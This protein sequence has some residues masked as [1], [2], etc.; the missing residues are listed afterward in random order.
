M[1]FR[2]GRSAIDAERRALLRERS[3]ID[4][5]LARLARAA[6]E[7]EPP[8]GLRRA[9]VAVVIVAVAALLALIAAVAI[10][11][12]PPSPRSRRDETL[13]RARRLRA[14]AHLFMA[15]RGG[16]PDSHALRAGGYLSGDA[17]G[18][19]AWG[20]PLSIRCGARGAVV[21]SPGPDGVFGSLDDLP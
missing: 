7:A 17:P 10:A 11:W 21:R 1:P 4:A 20:G 16:C 18:E 19:D 6:G 2:L 13:D 12:V 15:E 14:A 8:S 3:A 5:R 9:A